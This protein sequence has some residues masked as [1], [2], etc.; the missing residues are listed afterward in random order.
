VSRGC[1]FG[2]QIER[3]HRCKGSVQPLA[4]RDPD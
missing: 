4:R 3:A 2:R 1:G